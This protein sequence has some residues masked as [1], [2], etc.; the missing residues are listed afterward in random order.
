MPPLHHTIQEEGIIIS[1]ARRRSISSAAVG[2]YLQTVMA[3]PPLSPRS[4]HVN[5]LPAID[6]PIK[7]VLIK[8]FKYI[9]KIIF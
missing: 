3:A 7:S 1:G 9:L 5:T 4:N 2:P 6:E 8:L